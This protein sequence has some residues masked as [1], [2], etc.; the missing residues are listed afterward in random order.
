MRFLKCPLKME[1]SGPDLSVT[2]LLYL[3]YASLILEKHDPMLRK[4]IF[5][6]EYIY[7]FDIKSEQFFEVVQID[8]R[9]LLRKLQN[10]SQ[11][12]RD[13]LFLVIYFLSGGLGRS[14]SLGL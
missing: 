9:G 10:S 6:C 12:S 5:L 3:V 14:H 1:S 2:L 8:T 11:A 13:L 7:L 4:I